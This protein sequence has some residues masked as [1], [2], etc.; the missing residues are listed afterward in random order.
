MWMILLYIL[1]IEKKKKL[2][3]K[4]LVAK[5]IFTLNDANIPSSEK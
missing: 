3:F 1:N 5:E 2:H 4:K